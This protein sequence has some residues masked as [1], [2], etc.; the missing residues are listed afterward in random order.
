[1]TALL[2]TCFLLAVLD[3]DDQLHIP[4][5]ESLKAQQKVILPDVVIP[6]LAYMII[7]ELGHKVLSLFLR[8]I[9]RG[10]LTIEQSKTSDFTRA[11][12]LVES[13][14]DN[15]IDFVD[16]VIVAQAERLGITQILTVDQRHFRIFR[17][18][19]C[20]AFKILP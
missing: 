10:E 19:H 17:P 14:A 1:M 12:D 11:A 20:S 9:A 18:K 16:C 8:S 5:S 6:E 3:A 7:R 4:C 13:Y 15:H 2:D